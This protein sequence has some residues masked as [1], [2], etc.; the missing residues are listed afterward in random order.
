M[1]PL[2]FS[3]LNLLVLA[4]TAPWP[5]LAGAGQSVAGWPLWAVYTVAA[6]AAYAGFVAWS[7]KHYWGRWE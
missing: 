1:T 2:R 4:L 5:F 7:L 3:L 6:A